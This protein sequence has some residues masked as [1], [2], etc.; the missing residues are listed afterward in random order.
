MKTM[1]QQASSYLILL[2]CFEG[3]DENAKMYNTYIVALP[4][5]N[6]VREKT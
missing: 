3:D 1:S 2:F 5:G 4:D 6:V